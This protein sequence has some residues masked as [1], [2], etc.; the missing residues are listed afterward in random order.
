L[1]VVVDDRTTNRKILGRL[2]RT[3]EAGIEALEFDNPSSALAAMKYRLPDLIITDF[4]MPGMDGAEFVK[5]CREELADPEVPIIV[6]TAYED[7]D[8]RYRALEAGATDFLLSPIDHR[9]FRTRTINLL[10]L[11]RQQRSIRQRAHLLASELDRA[12]KQKAE[13]LLRSEEKLRRLID[14]V[15]ALIIESDAAG[16]CLL[17]NS[18]CRTLTLGA[19]GAM[20][21]VEGLFGP[22]YWR[23]HGPLDRSVLETGQAL[24]AF[25]EEVTDSLGR[26]RVLLTTKTPLPSEDGRDNAV[27]TVS[28]DITDRKESEERLVYQANY[29]YV[30]GL[31]NRL[32]ALDRLAQ[33]IVRARRNETSLAVLYVDLD[34]FKKVNDTVGHAV[35]DRLL[36]D[37]ADRLTASIRSSDTVA[38]LGGDE[39]LVILADLQVDHKPEAVVQTIIDEMNR[40]FYVAGHE[41]YVG[42]SVG[43]TM[44]PQDGAPPDELVRHA[45]A[46]MHR[47]KAAGGNAYRFF[48]R[49]MTEDAVRR[50]EMEALLRHVLERQELRLEYQPLADV[51]TGEI[52]GME[53]LVRWHSRELGIVPPDRFIPLAEETGLIVPIGQWIL[54][55]ACQQAA[56][57]QKQSRR[58]L[59][60]GIN[61]SYRQFV[62][63]D[64]VGQVSDALAETGLPADCLELEITERLL[65]QD[66]R[67]ALDFLSRLRRIGVRLAIDDFGTGYA[68]IMYLKRFP[69]T[70]LK[71]D[72][73]F[74]AD[75]TESSDGAALVTAIISMAH[76]LG[77]EV[78]AEGVEEEHQLDFL[79][80]LGCNCFQGYLLSRPTE[81][82]H[83]ERFI[84]GPSPQ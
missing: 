28:V 27:V 48:S 14:T 83:F 10:T 58:P 39:F 79:R 46:A 84:Q 59:R 42:A 77:L 66:V 67:L 21:T 22:A 8:F 70:T 15:P 61:V 11:G 50:V 2:A 71:I 18:F 53:A 54:R 69:F 5:H 13:T 75:A 63:T 45:D 78:V 38:R 47:A 34:G 55:T 72:K 82:K 20:E 31:P 81:P 32:L 19:E 73:V 33:G 7:R 52:I 37:V 62:G 1:V 49:D 80:R 76:G 68:S 41:F 25:E 4:N 12:L 64:F 65:M 36:V 17:A 35:G 6:I 74:V 43:L 30:T 16:R 26:Q 51:R 23:R 9:E 60:I 57:W 29:D 44:F 24:P 56:A 3:L 40:A